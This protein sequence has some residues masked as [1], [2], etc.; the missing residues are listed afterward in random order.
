MEFLAVLFSSL[1]NLKSCITTLKSS[2]S[3]TNL[4]Q[5]KKLHSYMLIN[6]F[7][8]SPFSIT[9]LINMYSKCNVI[10]DAF[11][12]FSFSSSNCEL[13]IFVYNAIIV[14]FI[15]ND[16]PNLALR[17]CEKMRMSGVMMDKFTFPCVVKA[18]PG[19][20]DAEGFKI[21]HGLVFNMV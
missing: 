9:S 4:Q 21:V 11:L 12:V 7:L 10:S 1:P 16:M 19:C 17:V 2:A 15:F 3:N 5:G 18:F 14:G 8:T 13:N 6:G 20:G